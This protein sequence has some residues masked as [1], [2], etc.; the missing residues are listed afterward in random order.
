MD[1]L[2]FPADFVFGAATAAYQIEGAW[3]VDGKGPSVWDKFSH[4][5]GKIKNGDTGDTACGHYYR[6]REDVALMK[7]LRL[8]AYRFSI[9][10][11]RV[12][13]EG[14][15][16]LNQKGLDFYKMLVDEL[17]EAHITPYVTLF[18][19][20]YPLALRDKGLGFENRDSAG[21]FAD[22]VEA[23][24]RELSGRVK[25]WITFNEPLVYATLGHL[26]G[27]HAPGIKSPKAFTSVVYHELL[28]HG[29]AVR[30]IRSI[31][32][33]AKVGITLNL[34]PIHPLKDTE[35][36]KL[37]VQSVDQAINRLF[38]DP[39][40]KGSFPEPL[41]KRLGLFHPQ[42]KADDMD[43]IQAPVDFLGVNNYTRAMAESRFYIP[44]LRARYIDSHPTEKEFERG[45]VQYTSM[46]WEVYP[47]GIYEL[48]MRIKNEYGNIPVYITENG[49]AFEDRL[50]GETVH[51]L[52]RIQY[53]EGYL[54]HVYAAIQEGA[55]AKGYFVWTLMDNFEWACGFS[56]RFGLV[57]VD[58]D[59]QRR[60]IKDSGH[61]YADIIKARQR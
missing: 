60:I 8:D 54:R 15:G 19:W 59:T 3:D 26:F 12:M 52:K 13:P 47:K 58:F 31:D 49:A 23:V 35:R 46:G 36:D 37:A 33:G 45:G 39:L 30:A 17:L 24:C 38:L 43:T 32:A 5:K 18:H 57:Y 42:T 50:E 53:L 34:M 28:A 25:N 44:F 7:S 16:A 40:F 51:D 22:Y 14:R 20:D 55:N 27:T 2:A 48:L 4:T 41:W 21:Y 29:L 6:F 9:S 56:K 61:Y 1:G 10:W 11:P